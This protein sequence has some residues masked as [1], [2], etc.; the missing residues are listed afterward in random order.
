MADRLLGCLRRVKSLVVI[1]ALLGAT[2]FVAGQAGD[3]RNAATWYQRSI[4]RLGSI[5]I[6]EAEWTVIREYQ[7]DPHGM[8]A[9]TVREILARAEPAL[10]AARRGTQQDYNDFGLD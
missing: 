2:G 1:A 10:S 8:P 9:A 5:E 6:T 7:R 4:A 3:S